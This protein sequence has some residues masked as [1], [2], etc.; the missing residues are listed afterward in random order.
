MIRGAS[1]RSRRP[2]IEQDVLKAVRL[3]PGASVDDLQQILPYHASYSELYSF[4]QEQAGQTN[5]RHASASL[6]VYYSGRNLHVFDLAV[7]AKY[8]ARASLLVNDQFRGIIRYLANNG[9]S[10]RAEIQQAPGVRGTSGL[11]T[12]L[13]K[14]VEDGYIERIPRPPETQL[15]NRNQVYRLTPD[16]IDCVNFPAFQRRFMGEFVR[17]PEMM[18]CKDFEQL[19]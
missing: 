2:T 11:N 12:R 7:P 19:E 3:W 15:T 9:P 10:S 8:H 6:A 18:R 14:L 13:S 1:L 17:T 4:V 16:M 5:R